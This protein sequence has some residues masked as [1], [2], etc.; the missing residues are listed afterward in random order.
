MKTRKI[1]MR[2]CVVTRES[3]PKQELLRVVKD[4]E[5]N[6]SVDVTGKANGRGAYVKKD[7]AVIDKARKTKVLERVLET[8]IKEEI[9]RELEDYIISSK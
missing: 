6:L 8:E 1:P 7:L 3:L 9:Y 5:N 4:K 2:T